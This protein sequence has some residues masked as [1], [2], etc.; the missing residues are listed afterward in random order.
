MRAADA[1][2]EVRPKPFNFVDVMDAGNV[3]NG[4]MTHGAVNIAKLGK[5]VATPEFVPANHGSRRDFCLN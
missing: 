2:L 1:A 4:T 3:F 5:V